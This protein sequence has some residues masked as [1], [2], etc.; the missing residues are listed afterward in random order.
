[1]TM[2]VQYKRWK[3][4][5]FTLGWLCL[6]FLM[7]VIFLAIS[8]VGIWQALFFVVLLLASCNI[9]YSIAV[10]YNMVWIGLVFVIIILII[11]CVFVWDAAF[12]N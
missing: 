12:G 8:N 1:M 10:R 2:R 6:S 7:M 5:A 4:I 11:G 3:I 9:A